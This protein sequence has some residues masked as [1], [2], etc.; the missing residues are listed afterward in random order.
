M[1]KDSLNGQRYLVNALLQVQC[2]FQRIYDRAP[3]VV[4]WLLDRGQDHSTS[5]PVQ[6]VHQFLSVLPFFEWRLVEELCKTWQ[7]HVVTSEVAG[8]CKW[9]STGLYNF[10]MEGLLTAISTAK[11]YVKMVVSRCSRVAGQF[12]I[13]IR[14]PVLNWILEKEAEK[15]LVWMNLS[16]E[17]HW[18]YLFHKKMKS[19]DS[20]DL[21]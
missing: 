21:V 17:S 11:L 19:W 20:Y 12:Q 6:V 4:G 7:R 18:W 2:G 8:L 1:V 16:T 10:K 13:S 9:R 15:A 3:F 14:F 5:S